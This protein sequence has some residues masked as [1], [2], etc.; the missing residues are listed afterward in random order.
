MLLCNSLYYQGTELVLVRS[1]V[2]FYIEENFLLSI[3]Y[4]VMCGGRLVIL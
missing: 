2:T 3:L 1:M 4:F